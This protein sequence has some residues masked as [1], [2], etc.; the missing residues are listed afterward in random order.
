MH[1]SVLV[2]LV[3]VRVLRVRVIVRIVTVLVRLVRVR[4]IVIVLVIDCVFVLLG[5]ILCHCDCSAC[6]CHSC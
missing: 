6:Y 1:V 3:C 4:V 2:V 5:S